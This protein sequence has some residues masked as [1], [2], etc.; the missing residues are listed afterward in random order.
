MSVRWEIKG[1]QGQG[2]CSQGIRGL[3]G[4]PIG[5]EAQ[6]LKRGCHGE[7]QRGARQRE[8][9]RSKALRWERV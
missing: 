4:G 3:V 2:C 9:T 1:K 8:R 6:M 7:I 5:V